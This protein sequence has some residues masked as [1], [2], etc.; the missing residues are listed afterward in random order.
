[1]R[2][3]SLLRRGYRAITPIYTAEGI[4]ISFDTADSPT[5]G[6]KR[7]IAIVSHSQGHSRHYHLDIPLDD[8]GAQGKV[9]KT[10]VQATGSSNSYARRYLVCMIFNVTTEDDNDGNKDKGAHEMADSMKEGFLT[11]I[12]ALA[13]KKAAESLWQSI[14]SECTTAGDVNAYAALKAALS[15][16][17]K[18]IN[19]GG[20]AI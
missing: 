2:K 10:A 9:N 8:A 19:A 3:P 14:A 5:V 4:S 1:M 16:K 7:I 13:D 17:V 11:A 12:E 15:A 18:S 6:L 20:K